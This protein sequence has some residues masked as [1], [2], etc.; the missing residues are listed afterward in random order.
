MDGQ[1]ALARVSARFR[2][3]AARAQKA[4]QRAAAQAEKRQQ[5]LENGYVDDE[6]S[7]E[8][9]GMVQNKHVH[10]W[11]VLSNDTHNA[12]DDVAASLT[13][14]TTPAADSYNE[15]W[16]RRWAPALRANVCSTQRSE[17][18]E[19]LMRRLLVGECCR[20]VRYFACSLLDSQKGVQELE[21][22]YFL[23]PG[24]ISLAFRMI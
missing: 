9:L 21:E 5:E 12:E 15:V 3:S 2:A 22:K 14:T 8:E 17:V 18:L 24:D 20:K 10:A 6:E 1:D 13:R 7:Y 11:Q 4:R 16:R 23:Y 19:P